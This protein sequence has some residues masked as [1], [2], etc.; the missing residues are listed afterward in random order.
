MKKKYPWQDKDYLKQLSIRQSGIP[1]ER[2][3]KR[4]LKLMQ[5]IQSVRERLYYFNFQQSSMRSSQLVHSFILELRK[6]SNPPR[7]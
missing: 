4:F 6:E 5:D 3:P 2:F 1:E 7:I